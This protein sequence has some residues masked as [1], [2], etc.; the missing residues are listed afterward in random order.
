MRAVRIDT[1]LRIDGVLDEGVYREV[2]SIADFRQIEPEEGAP[3]SEPTEIWVLFDREHLYIVARCADSQPDRIVANDMRRDGANITQNDNISIVI[4]TFFDRRN[5]YEFLVTPVGGMMDSQVTD[6]RDVN[7]DWNTV[8]SARSRLTDEGWTTEVRIPFRSL[9][10]QGAGPQVW[11]L[12]VRRTIRWKNEYAYLNPV[13]RSEGARGILRFSMAAPL[14]GLDID[15]ESIG[16]DVKPYALGAARADR[17]L[18]PLF[19]TE[20]DADAGFDVK[21][22]ITRSLTADFTLNT[23]FAQVEDDDQQVN[24]TRFSLL[25]PEKREFFL[26]G[27]GIFGFGGVESSPR[28][29]AT[30]PTNTPV[31]FF[32]RAIGLAGDRAVPINAGGRLT[33][34]VGKY[35]VG[36]LQIRTGDEEVAGLPETDFSVVRVKRD[37]LRRSSV[38]VIGTRRSA[39]GAGT[40]TAFG[41]DTG[42]NFFQ[43]LNIVG[44]YAET[45]TPGLE[46]ENRSYRGR[47]AYDADLFGLT[48]EHLAVGRNF[49][50]QIG[51][52]RRDGFVESLAQMRVSRRPQS[53]ESVRKISVETGFDY[54]TDPDGRVENRQVRAA[55][56][57]ELQSSDSWTI[58]YLHDYEFVPEPF[59]IPGGIVV[60]VG[61]YRFSSLI[62]RYTIGAQHRVAGDVTLAYSGFY[63][64][65][66]AEAGYR[67]RVEVTRR[68]AVEPGL[69]VFKLDLPN[70]ETTAALVSVRTTYSFR[71]NMWLAALI[72][73]NSANHLSTANVRFRWEYWPGSDLFVVYSDGRNT[74]LRGPER[75]QN[76][77]FT[78]KMTRLFRF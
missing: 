25:Y 20:G 41:I 68:L 4:D 60:P 33:G 5:G 22:G 17:V 63:G 31:L 2:P 27:Q 9:R 21:Y 65:T 42:L 1:P 50:P 29:A 8:W 15:V 37:I 10:Y 55:L 74:L 39:A 32:S 26:E 43:F 75:L 38:G 48:L 45:R 70:D 24:L 58:E 62:G 34:R 64:G 19:R 18:D 13:P 16:L 51:F 57:T 73:H 71:P 67:G 49:D 66:R 47:L 28:R 77:G 52:L 23:D 44:Y 11:G 72:Q 3:V 14:V 56:R 7:R 69:S 53:L 54:I 6:E 12:N 35:S 78:V 36:L 76:R 59:T 30:A 40:N 61:A 46:G